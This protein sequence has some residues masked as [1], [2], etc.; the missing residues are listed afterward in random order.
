MKRITRLL[1]AISITYKIYVTKFEGSWCFERKTALKTGNCAKGSIHT[2]SYVFCVYSPFS[3]GANNTSS[4]Y[5]YFPVST[6]IYPFPLRFCQ[7]HDNFRGNLQKNWPILFSVSLEELE[8][9]LFITMKTLKM[10]EDLWMTRWYGRILSLSGYSDITVV[11]KINTVEF[12]IVL[13]FHSITLP[14]QN[15]QRYNKKE[16]KFSNFCRC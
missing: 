4:V 2:G 7:N 11:V 13:K 3:L 12:R 10:S 16:I 14:Y 9:S 15:T 5:G 6:R 1:A 8:L